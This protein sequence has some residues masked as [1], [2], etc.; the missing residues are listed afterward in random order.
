MGKVNTR[1]CSSVLVFAENKLHFLSLS[2]SLSIQLE[3]LFRKVQEPKIEPAFMAQ[4]CEE[5]F[6]LG[7]R[8]IYNSGKFLLVS[9]NVPRARLC[10]TGLTVRSSSFIIIGLYGFFVLTNT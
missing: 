3:T 7:Y 5:L 4:S 1:R 2:L 10:L 8:Q 9:R 6:A